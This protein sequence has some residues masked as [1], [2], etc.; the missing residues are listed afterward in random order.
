M[1]SAT[2]GRMANEPYI[3]QTPCL[4]TLRQ[5]EQT[6]IILLLWDGLDIDAACLTLCST[7]QC[8]R[9]SQSS[10]GSFGYIQFWRPLWN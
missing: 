7:I 4:S 6:L 9:G 10:I 1:F 3:L 8:F 5:V 2:S